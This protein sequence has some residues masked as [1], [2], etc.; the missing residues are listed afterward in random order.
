[1]SDFGVIHGKFY[2][3]PRKVNRFS[4]AH[5]FYFKLEN[6]KKEDISKEEKE[7][8]K[9][10]W[11]S[12]DELKKFLTPDSHHRALELL[13]GKA[14]YTGEGRLTNSGKFD[15]SESLEVREKIT[16]YVNG[17]KKK[18]YK[19]R[20]W[21]V[22]RQRYWGAPIPIV[23]DKEGKPHSIPKEYLPW[24]LP[25]DVEFKP[26]GISPLAESKELRGRVENIF[27][28]GWRPEVD[29][30]DTFV[31]SSWYFFRFAD[32]K[33]KKE[34]ASHEQIKK[35]LP[36]NLYMGGA[37]HT[38]LHLMY[39]RFFTK[40]LEKLKYIDFK[41]PFSKLRH[42]GMILA[43]DGRKMSKSF[44][45]II[46]P[47]EI[48]ERFGADTMRIY[49]MFMGPLADSKPWNT[50]N[51]MGARRF[52]ER[53]W[54]L[55]IKVKNQKSSLDKNKELDTLLHQTI[56]KVGSDI[57][58]LKFNTAISQMMILMNALE[59]ATVV[60]LSSY[61]ILVQLVAPFAPHV[62]EE[63]WQKMGGTDSVHKKEWPQFD[64]SHIIAETYTIVVQINGKVRAKFEASTDLSEA[65]IKE[66]SLS[67]ERIRKC[68]SGKKPQRIIY[69]FGK[70]VNIV[71]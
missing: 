45:N 50:Q 43:E 51:I 54:R 47:D 55:Q 6:G 19:L 40:V 67:M 60:N 17:K 1:M 15:E 48:V 66:K 36:V 62:A 63:L 52:I 20:D 33:N 46:N 56:K 39:A 7:N 3:V 10:L 68:L 53:I 30:M 58:N 28:K 59:K 29:T 24:L 18:T 27:G 25:T 34:F 64:E 16:A 70:I 61:K 57:E 14:V 42:Q 23:Y 4:H 37:E 32:P 44:G 5:T 65:Q 69:V 26:T 71:V 8:H 12:K 9:I 41:E 22:S 13:E 31:C 11:L 35:W 38:V 21:L 49:E 2:H